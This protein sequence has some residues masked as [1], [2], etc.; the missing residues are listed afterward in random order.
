[1]L[2]QLGKD[3]LLRLELLED[4]LEHEVAVG[5]VVVGRGGRDDRGEEPGLTLAVAALGDLFLE[6]LLDGRPGVCERLFADVTDGDRHLEAAEDERGDL[7][8]HQAGADDSDLADRLRLLIWPAGRI[9]GPAL[10][11]VEGVQRCLRL[12]A[13]K[14]LSDGLRKQLEHFAH[15]DESVRKLGVEVCSDIC[16]QALDHGVAG[17]HFYCL[18]R[19]PSCREIM[20]NLGRAP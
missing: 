19:V 12:A 16:R 17:L 1:M 11:E 5:E 13:G 2:A 14:Q 15:D 10:D 7:S 3:L 9:L 8:R 18:N 4:G 20:T 6:L